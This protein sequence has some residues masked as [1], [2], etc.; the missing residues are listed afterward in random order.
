MQQQAHAATPEAA[1]AVALRQHAIQRKGKSTAIFDDP[2]G[3]ARHRAFVTA[4][5]SG[6]T[7]RSVLRIVLKCGR[8]GR[9]GRFFFVV[10][11]IHTY[12]HPSRFCTTHHRIHP[13]HWISLRDTTK[14]PQLGT[15][16]TQI[17]ASGAGQG[18]AYVFICSKCEKAMGGVGSLCP[19]SRYMRTICKLLRNSYYCCRLYINYTRSKR[20]TD[21]VMCDRCHDSDRPMHQT[22]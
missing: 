12:R 17:V 6:R 22:K 5:I 20:L 16:P 8:F 7:V 13:G 2:T 19:R 9:F 10:S 1:E 4:R 3:C 18:K 15:Q 21:D 14:A 11:C